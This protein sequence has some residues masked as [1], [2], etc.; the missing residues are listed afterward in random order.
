M[1]S[2]PAVT[3]ISFT[4][5]PTMAYPGHYKRVESARALST[6]T[7]RQC[8]HRAVHNEEGTSANFSAVF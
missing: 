4:E 6:H 8:H 7:R 5:S 2:V 1:S 3:R